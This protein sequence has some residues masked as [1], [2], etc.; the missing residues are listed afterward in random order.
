VL[1]GNLSV[2]TQVIDATIK[3]DHFEQ[4]A[5]VE[6]KRLAAKL[7]KNFFTFRLMRDLV[8]DYLYLYNNKDFSTRQML[9]ST[10]GIA[11]SNPK[12]LTNRSKR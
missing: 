1:K 11:V 12:Y 4:V 2:A 6:H 3:L 5:N 8:A 7:E 10:W 9:G